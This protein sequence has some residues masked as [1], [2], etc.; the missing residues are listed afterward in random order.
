MGRRCPDDLGTG[1]FAI[2]RDKEEGL[3]VRLNK[4]AGN[5]DTSVGPANCL[6]HAGGVAVVGK[7]VRALF[8]RYEKKSVR[9]FT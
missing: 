9:I 8:F 3:G 7:V 1:G 6:E 4:L 5:F 2:S